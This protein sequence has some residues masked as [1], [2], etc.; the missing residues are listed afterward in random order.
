VPGLGVQ[1]GGRPHIGAAGGRQRH[2][3]KQPHRSSRRKAQR[4][5]RKQTW[6]ATRRDWQRHACRAL[7]RLRSVTGHRPDQSLG[8]TRRWAARVKGARSRGRA[9]QTMGSVRQGSRIKVQGR[10]DYGQ[11]ASRKTRSRSR[12]DQTMGSSH[13][14]EFPCKNPL[15]RVLVAH[16]HGQ[17]DHSAVLL[18]HTLTCQPA[19]RCPPSP[20]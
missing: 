6:K 13:Q 3:C 2:A 20:A 1:V 9:D 17:P 7:Q 10:P 4:H 19:V 18:G 15:S 5:A 14:G 12:A 16:K 11:R 8:Q